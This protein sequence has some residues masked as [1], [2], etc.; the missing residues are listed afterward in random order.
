MSVDKV[1]ALGGMAEFYNRYLVP[2]N[3]ASYAE[4]V[5][6]RVKALLPCRI[7]ELRLAAASRRL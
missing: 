4:V 2:L 3:F 7:L 5:A 1:S 6:D